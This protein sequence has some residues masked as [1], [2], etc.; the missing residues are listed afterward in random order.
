[1]IIFS[2][3]QSIREFRGDSNRFK[4]SRDHLQN[5]PRKPIILF[6]TFLSSRED[7]AMGGWHLELWWPLRL[8]RNY[9]KE[10][11]MWR[12]DDEVVI[13]FFILWETV[14]LIHTS[15][16]GPTKTFFQP[17]VFPL[18]VDFLFNSLLRKTFFQP[19]NLFQIM[20]KGLFHI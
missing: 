20:A 4:K 17:T 10:G 18:P 8:D 6:D 2:F 13:F 3:L 14:R 12:G 9:L 19:N 1:M 16:V 7:R 11:W 5:L 15:N